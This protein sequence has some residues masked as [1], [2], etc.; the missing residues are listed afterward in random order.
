MNYL[1]IFIINNIKKFKKI[2]FF[3]RKGVVEVMQCY[4]VFYFFKFFLKNGGKKV[5]WRLLFCCFLA[6]KRVSGA[7]IDRPKIERRSIRNR[8]ANLKRSYLETNFFY[9][10]KNFESEKTYDVRKVVHNGLASLKYG[11][12]IKI[13]FKNEEIY[14]IL[15]I[16]HL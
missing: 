4:F 15:K 5:P 14:E 1:D 8:R 6:R 7:S 12:G 3:N 9:S 10:T 11:G 13:I 2:F 16:N